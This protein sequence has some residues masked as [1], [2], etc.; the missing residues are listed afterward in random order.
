MIFDQ[1]KGGV[2]LSYGQMVSN[3]LVKFIYTPFLLHALGQNEYGLFSL[4]MSIVGYLAILDMGF[5]STVTRYT[6]KYRT[7]NDEEKLLNLYGTL[8]VVYIGIGVLALVVCAI[9]NLSA[10][11]LFSNTMT[12]DEIGKIRLMIIL[13][14]LNL[15]FSFPLQIARSV[16]IA[17]ERFI[18][19][20][21]LELIRTYLQPLTLVLLLYFVHIKSVGAIVV[22]TFFNLLTY[23]IYYIYAVRNLGFRFSI[24]AFCPDMIP[25]LFKFSIWMFFVMLFEQIQYNSGQFILGL[26]KDSATIAIWGIAMI[27]V[28]NYRAL[29]T[30]ISNV[31]LPTIISSK[32]RNNINE[33]NEVI[34]KMTRYQAIIL[35]IVLLNFIL[36]GSRFLTLWAGQTYSEAYNACVLIMIPM[37]LALIM[38]FSYLYQIAAN[39]L[40]YRVVTLFSGYLLSFVT[41]YT[42]TEITIESYAVI[43][44]ISMIFGQIIAPLFYVKRKM[45]VNMIK[46]F[47]DIV[48]AIIA[49]SLISIMMFFVIEIIGGYS[50]MLFLVELLVYN[51]VLL[52]CIYKFSF[53]KYEKD[54][55]TQKIKHRR[56]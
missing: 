11:R 5:G 41:I 16:L 52:T 29:S 36:F 44:A 35:I 26:F 50:T 15:L 38:D 3:V 45:R 56:A 30:A 32:V 55:L 25:M 47:T 40:R 22:V 46:L 23:L 31:Y 43:I 37:F 42:L 49:P 21:G 6:V 9:L 33:M 51:L 2:V 4:I 17:Y 12:I 20:N 48:R 19:K 14:G 18:F 7:E 39:E 1:K 8:S 10:D 28:L 13:C 54:M 34:Y 53:N 24:R 27:F